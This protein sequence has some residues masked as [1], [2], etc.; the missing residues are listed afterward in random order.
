MLAKVA[1]MY[2]I[3]NLTQA[4]I[5][6]RLGIY[7]TTISRYLK[8]AR[9]EGIVD[10]TIRNDLNDYCQLE[11]DLERRFGLKEAIIV[12]SD[13]NEDDE[14]I[15]E[16]LG[17][18]CA[19]FLNRLIQDKDIV[20][21]TWGT[22]V[23]EVAN[24]LGR[25]HNLKKVHAEIIPI[26]GGPGDASN[27]YHVNTIV[28]KVADAFDAKPRYF[29][30][31]VVTAEKETRDAILAD[32]SMQ[33]VVGLWD[34]VDIAVHGIGIV[35]E[36]HSTLSTG[37]VEQKELKEIVKTGAVAD[38]C[39]NFVDPDG[40]VRDLEIN[41]RTIGLKPPQL[42]KIKY[43]IGVA[44]SERKVPAIYAVLKGHY[45]NVLVT[46]EMTAKALIEMAKSRN[47]SLA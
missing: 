28:S 37:Y 21:F 20:G 2:Y 32:R 8:S 17:R 13:N 25:M 38:I 12:P 3:E 40:S 29:Y 27:E 33:S 24:A 14:K 39:S 15:K 22:T 36:N 35:S 46:N 42:R 19:E 30:A 44:A 34:K 6:K 26:C 18:A 47:E 31:P 41:S 7:R 11:T 9:E 43:S 4:E 45:I 10:I 5:A 23:S 16:I 1:N